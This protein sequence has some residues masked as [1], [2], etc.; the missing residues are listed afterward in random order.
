MQLSRNHTNMTLTTLSK[1]MGR[2]GLMG[3]MGLVACGCAGT[4]PP[5]KGEQFLFNI[6]TN[7]QPQVVWV[8]NVVVENLRP[9]S[10]NLK[11]ETVTPLVTLEDLKSVISDLKNPGAVLLTNSLPVVAWVT[12]VVRETNW[13]AGY[14]LS[15]NGNAQAVAGVAGTLSNLGMPGAGSLV[16]MGLLGIAAAWAGYRNR[17]Y[18]GQNAA[19]QQASGVMAQNIATFME[20][21]QQTSQGKQLAPVLRNYLMQHQA[22]AGVMEQIVALAGQVDPLKAQGMAQAFLAGA[23]ELRKS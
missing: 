11:P 18:A 6:Q 13:V 14:T 4:K 15:P 7:L 23:A 19:L 22:E 21:L 9:E 8:T 16:T 10:G 3:L 2:M 20:V 17:Q 5:T 12:N 1:W